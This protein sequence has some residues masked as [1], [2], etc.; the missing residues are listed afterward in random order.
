MSKM[1]PS[2]PYPLLH[3]M[4][5]LT[6]GTC[7]EVPFRSIYNYVSRSARKQSIL[8]DSN[9]LDD[10]DTVNIPK[11]IP[12]RIYE[13]ELECENT[14]IKLKNIISLFDLYHKNVKFYNLQQE[15]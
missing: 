11:D 9:D 4:A 1:I 15:S 6:R 3:R 7:Q 12:H 2:E 5:L 10:L 14:D 8:D 13:L